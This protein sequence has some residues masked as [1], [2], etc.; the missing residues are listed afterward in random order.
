VSGGKRIVAVIAARGGSKG[1]PRK[2]VLPLAGRPLIAWSVMAAQGSALIDRTIVSTDDEEIAEAARAAGGEVPFLRP[3]DLATDSASIID[4]M[5]HAVD[6]LG[7]TPDYVVLL[8]ATS[9]LRLASDIDDCIRL[10]LDNDAPAA[11]TITPAAKSPY[12]M[13]LRD[14]DGRVRPVIERETVGDQRQSLPPAF[15]ANGA[16]Y[17]ARTDWLRRERTFWR[18]GQTLGHV[19]PAERSVD[20]DSLLDFRL[21][22]LLMDD[23]PAVSS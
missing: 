22:Q 7:E 12:W 9:P 20:I 3:A 8:Q 10:C 1:L 2:N 4:A 14:D 16:V 17:V 6:T 18:P 13:F 21:A 15:A 23:V 5:L 19:M 11:A